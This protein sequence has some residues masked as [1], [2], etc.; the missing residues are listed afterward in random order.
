M[1]RGT[2]SER[3]GG[4]GARQNAPF[5]IHV[6]FAE[7]VPT[8]DDEG[9]IRSP[10]SGIVGTNRARRG[11][12]RRHQMG[13]GVLMTQTAPQALCS[14]ELSR[15]WLHPVPTSTK[16]SRPPVEEARTDKGRLV[17]VCASKKE[18]GQIFAHMLV[19]YSR[20]RGPSDP[21]VETRISGA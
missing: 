13:S 3:F 6:P 20:S 11:K 21:W 2:W 9:E 15:R 18:V 16:L 17:D 5:L 10:L 12:A 1:N 4:G 19:S 8:S 14:R 7:A